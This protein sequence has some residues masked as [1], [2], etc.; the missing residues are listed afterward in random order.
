MSFR[1]LICFRVNRRHSFSTYPLH[2][3]RDGHPSVFSDGVDVHKSDD[4]AEHTLSL[5]N[6]ASQL[7]T[8]LVFVP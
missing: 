4:G 5:Y 2:D 7:D 8:L 6:L 3:A 1:L